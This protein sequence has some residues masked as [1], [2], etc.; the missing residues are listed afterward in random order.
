MPYP[1]E[2]LD[3]R[4][5]DRQLQRFHRQLPDLSSPSRAQAHILL[6]GHAL[7]NRTHKNPGPCP[8]CMCVCVCVIVCKREIE[9][10]GESMVHEVVIGI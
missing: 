10:E 8:E 2:A 4:P 1:S 3:L 5:I 6:P 9:L 7:R